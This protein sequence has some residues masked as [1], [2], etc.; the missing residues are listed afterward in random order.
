M[1]KHAIDYFRASHRLMYVSV[2]IISFAVAS[3]SFRMW[4]LAPDILFA[5][6]ISSSLAGIVV[7]IAG[8]EGRSDK[9]GPPGSRK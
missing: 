9:E 6:I 4:D 1:V 7:F 5:L 2:F 3:F 8:S